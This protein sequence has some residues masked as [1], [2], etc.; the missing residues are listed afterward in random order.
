[1]PKT[2]QIGCHLNAT[3]GTR[4][5]AT[6]SDPARFQVWVDGTTLGGDTAA[7][8]CRPG[9]GSVESGVAGENPDPE[10]PRRSFPRNTDPSPVRQPRHFHASL[11]AKRRCPTVTRFAGLEVSLCLWGKAAEVH[12]GPDFRESLPVSGRCADIPGGPLRLRPRLQAELNAPIY[13]RY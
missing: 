2:S 11:P 8:G 1:M 9:G 10:G 5:T 6:S 13:R 4:V 7:A 3:A 12:Q